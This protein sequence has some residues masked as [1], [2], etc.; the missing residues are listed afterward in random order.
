M[1]TP[2]VN[3]PYTDFTKAE[4]I[5][6]LEA[7]L[8]RA[9][10]NFNREYPVV[11]GGKEYYTGDVLES[12]NPA[13]TQQ[14]IGRVHRADEKLTQRAVETAAKAFEKWSRVPGRE[15]A[16]YLLNAAARMR[17]RKLD[18]TALM[19]LE[20]GKNWAEADA[21]VAEAIDFLDF[22]AREIMRLSHPM[23]GTPWPGEL[24]E[25]FYIPLGP[26]AVIPP[27]NFP[28]AILAGMTSAALVAGN[29]VVLKPSSESPVLGYLVFDLFRECGLPAGVL[30]FLPGSGGR[31]GDLLVT[32]PKTRMIAFTGSK[33][34]GLRIN[35]LAAQVS[36]GQ[37]W[38]KRVI[39]EMG[40]KDTIVVDETA[41][42]EAASQGIFVAAFGFQGQKCSAC[43]RAIVVDAVYNEVLKGVVERAKA[44]KMG[45][46][47]DR[48]NYL[49][50]VI[51]RAAHESILN[52]IKIGKKEGKLKCG[53]KAGPAEGYFIEPTI[54]AD[55]APDARISRE[56]IFGPVLAFLK[57]KNFKDA[58]KI[59]NNTEYGLTGAAFSRNREHLSLARAEFHVGNL[60]LNR[61]CTGALV[62]VQPFGG[63]NMSGT[64]SKAG[65]RDYLQLFMQ[66]K[67]VCEKL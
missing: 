66:A 65:G 39:A 20:T 51:S 30:N 7:A 60:Y 14:V 34:V 22:Y 58:L 37:T 21:D 25:T 31:V 18:F 57:A 33:E 19:V 12:L 36:P 15:R 26:V 27:W 23:P 44:I 67:T 64:D 6:A 40:G 8:A 42:L 53:G 55:V 13:E 3:E 47:K 38:I 49:G 50:P 5:E 45:P 62:D 59:A 17:E 52:Y 1:L 28:V 9:E 10:E 48:Q 46:P 16:R 61:K 41:D 4:K 2:F 35:Q 54:I 11:V 43:S 24:N 29:S 56:E 63:F 32:H